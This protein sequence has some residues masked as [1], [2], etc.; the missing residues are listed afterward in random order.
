MP[1]KEEMLNSPI[2]IINFLSWQLHVYP[3]GMQ[4]GKDQYLSVFIGLRDGDENE[5]YISGWIQSP[6]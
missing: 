3:T 5:D 6:I 1:T 4:T 2:F